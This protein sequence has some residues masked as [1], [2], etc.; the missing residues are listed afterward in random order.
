MGADQRAEQ[1]AGSKPPIRLGDEEGEL[2]DEV[3]PLAAPLGND[4][5][6]DQHLDA[7]VVEQ[8][9]RSGAQP[10][11]GGIRRLLEAADDLPDLPRRGAGWPFAQL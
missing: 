10:V 2:G 9:Q 3:G 11:E 4:Q 6:V 5:Q 8:L 1:R 7:L